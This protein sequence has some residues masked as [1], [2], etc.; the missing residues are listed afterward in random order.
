MFIICV[1]MGICNGGCEV[2]SF[3]VSG[4][5]LRGSVTQKWAITFEDL[6]IFLPL[7]LLWIWHA[8]QM[9]GRLLGIDWGGRGDSPCGRR[10]WVGFHKWKC[11]FNYHGFVILSVKILEKG[12]RVSWML[13]IC[14]DSIR[15][16]NS[17]SAVKL[18]MD[19][20]CVLLFP[21]VVFHH[22]HMCLFHN[23]LH[24]SAGCSQADQK[25][26]QWRR[27]CWRGVPLT[28]DWSAEQ[29]LSWAMMSCDE[30]WTAQKHWNQFSA[31]QEHPFLITTT[32]N[33]NKQDIFLQLTDPSIAQSIRN[34]LN[35][36]VT[37]GINIRK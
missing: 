34:L 26:T 15:S 9:S 23:K 30:E 4:Q 11:C 21:A 27:S 7:F 29:T 32:D 2:V 10:L 1:W 20:L 14:P 19:C 16:C 28:V 25:V 31:H 22:L 18:S 37:D 5:K 13:P 12:G 17:I 36:S 33:L 8:V 6:F 3:L 35:L 24:A